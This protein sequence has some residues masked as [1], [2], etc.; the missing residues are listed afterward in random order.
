MILEKPRHPVQDLHFRITGPVVAELQEAFANDW[1]FATGEVLDGDI[2]FPRLSEAG[3][4]VARVITDGP[5][6]DFDN[7]HG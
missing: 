1:A 4:V 7:L 2:W 5:D 3:E 6:G